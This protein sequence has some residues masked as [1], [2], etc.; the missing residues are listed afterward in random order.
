M[1]GVQPHEHV[2]AVAAH[3]ELQAGAGRGS[4]NRH[5]ECDDQDHRLETILL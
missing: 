4:R 3:K 2:Y 5:D 1:I